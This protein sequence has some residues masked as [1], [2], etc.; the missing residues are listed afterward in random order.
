MDLYK[1]EK[2]RTV[3]KY[4]LRNILVSDENNADRIIKCLMQ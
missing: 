3:A 1:L 4:E 2:P